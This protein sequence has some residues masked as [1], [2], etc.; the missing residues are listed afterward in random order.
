MST[1][2]E[3]PTFAALLG[4]NLRLMALV[5][6]IAAVAWLVWRGLAAM[7]PD[8]AWLQVGAQSH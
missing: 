8:L 5:L 7:F 2:R 1:D 3:E 6:A 4:Q